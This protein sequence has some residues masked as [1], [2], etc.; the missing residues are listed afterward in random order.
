M[1][2][3]VKI[4]KLKEKRLGKY[5]LTGRTSE[6][7]Y[8]QKLPRFLYEELQS[9]HPSHPWFVL[10]PLEQPVTKKVFCS[11]RTAT[12]SSLYPKL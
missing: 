1:Q 3:L 8:W 4:K 11:L 5:I 9:H 7:T 6:H 10:R 2:I 12:K